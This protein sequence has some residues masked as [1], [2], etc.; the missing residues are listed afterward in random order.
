MAAAG[1]HHCPH[2]EEL[3]SKKSYE[4]HKRLYYDCNTGWIKKRRL[5]ADEEYTR[6]STAEQAIEQFAFETDDS[7]FQNADETNVDGN[8]ESDRPPLLV[9]FGDEIMDNSPHSCHTGETATYS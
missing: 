3:L 1:K 6:V 4:A 9:D 2:C 7:E 8:E 5:T